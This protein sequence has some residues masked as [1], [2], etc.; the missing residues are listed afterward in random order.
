MHLFVMQFTHKHIGV[1]FPLSN[2]KQLFICA[3]IP[4]TVMHSGIAAEID[5]YIIHRT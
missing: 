4:L 5:T 2:Y 3:A 1:H